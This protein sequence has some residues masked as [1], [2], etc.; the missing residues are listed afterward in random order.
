MR[1]WWLSMAVV[2][3]GCGT[4]GTTYTG[5]L[6]PLP[7]VAT[8]SAVVQVVPQTER[9]IVLVPG[10]AQPKVVRVSAEARS[11]TPIPGGEVVAILGGSTKVP[12]VDLLD[13][14][15]L[16]A[17]TLELPGP[18]DAVIPSSDGA[19]ALFTYVAGARTT[20]LVARNLNEVALLELGTR[21]VTRLSLDTESLAPRGVVFGPDEPDRR[22]VAVAL[23]RGVAVL[24]A[25]HPEVSPRR[26]SVRLS[27]SATES[28]VLETVFSDDAHWLF[29]RVQGQDDVVV[30]ELGREVGQPPS[31]SINFVS[32]GTGL[33]DLEAAPP[34]VAD[35][36][37]AVYAGSKEA[38]LLD[39]RG[40]Q[41]RAKRF[42]LPVSVTQVTRMRGSQVLL[43]APGVRTLAAWDVAD[44]RTGTLALD[45]TPSSPVVVPALDAALFPLV[46]A[47]D[48]SGFPAALASVSLEG[49]TN[50]VRLLLKGVQLAK[51]LSAVARDAVAQRLFFSVQQ[52]P[53]LVTMDLST[54]ELA[55]VTLD[56]EVKSLLALPAANAV[57]AVHPGGDVTVLPAGAVDRTQAIHF[58]D[59][60]WA[61]AFERGNE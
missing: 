33:S 45:G 40:I 12:T 47:T 24:D 10:D 5:K 59:V 21:T 15:S 48:G 52:S 16:E 9:A 46:G 54:L 22:L 42:G 57:A 53:Q 39:A 30:V 25:K 43:W 18:Y 58:E 26:V 37:V 60:L 55:E 19:Y 51:P 41:D 11:A 49:E 56:A 32:G 31:A 4:R 20:Q 50:R 8:P 36:V 6:T 28:R 2:A 7:W 17:Q 35:G 29:L 13:V 14:S 38:W 1:A 27:S 44:G 34:G 61:E 23:D 3:V